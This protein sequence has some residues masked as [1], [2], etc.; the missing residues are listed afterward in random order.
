M[1][2]SLDYVEFLSV[3]YPIIGGPSSA[4]HLDI[5]E[6]PEALKASLE[7]PVT[8]TSLV[9]IAKHRAWE[10][11]RWGVKQG[12]KYSESLGATAR[13]SWAASA[14]EAPYYPSRCALL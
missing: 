7:S 4:V 2:H 10:Y 5:E 3:V 9:H 14:Y 11:L 8:G 1:L 6:H 13:S 12:P